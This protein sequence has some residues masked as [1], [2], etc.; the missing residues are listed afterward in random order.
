MLALARTGPAGL[1]AVAEMARS[2][3]DEERAVAVRALPLTGPESQEALPV[4]IAALRDRNDEVR[5]TASSAFTLRS[6][7]QESPEIAAALFDSLQDTSESVRRDAA[8]SIGHA[9]PALAWVLARLKDGDEWLR[10][11]AA[12]ALGLVEEEVVRDSSISSSRANH[13]VLS[14]LVVPAL[15]E[16]LKDQSESVRISA[17][18]ALKRFG[19]PETKR[20]LEEALK[21]SAE[22]VRFTAAL[23]LVDIGSGDVVVLLLVESLSSGREQQRCSAASA[24]GQMLEIQIRRKTLRAGW[25]K[26]MTRSVDRLSFLDTFPAVPK[27]IQALEARDGAMRARELSK[28]AGCNP[29]ACLQDGGGGN[30]SFISCGGVSTF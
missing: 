20:A 17:A 27:I 1:G 4:L 14:K 25:R 10:R 13:E 23:S 3:N 21:D 5:R 16:A 11:R 7:K 2:G 22:G 29:A 9:N 28:A 19:G 8:S 15:V 18:A 30:D 24:L 26:R 12:E 6:W